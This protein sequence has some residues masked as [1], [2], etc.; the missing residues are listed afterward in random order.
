LPRKEWSQLNINPVI[1]CH[2]HCWY[3]YAADSARWANKFRN[4]RCKLCDEFVPHPHLEALDR[5]TPRQSPKIVFVDGH[6]DWNGKGV[7][8]EWL[9]QILEVRVRI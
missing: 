7:K 9:E 8:R 6:F 5:I 1:G 2:N 3:C 4:P